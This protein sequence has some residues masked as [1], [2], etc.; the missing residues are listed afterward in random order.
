[1]DNTVQAV[2][3]F[4]KLLNGKLKTSV[5]LYEPKMDLRKDEVYILL[6]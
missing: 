2:E 3:H 5:K 1:M 4:Y 6:V